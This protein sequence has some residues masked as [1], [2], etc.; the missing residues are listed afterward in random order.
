MPLQWEFR[1]YTSLPLASSIYGGPDATASSTSVTPRS[2]RS[3]TKDPLSLHIYK[4]QLNKDN[5]YPARKKEE[6]KCQ[7]N[8]YGAEMAQPG[9]AAWLFRPP[10]RDLP[11]EYAFFLTE[12]SK[13][14][15]T[16]KYTTC[17][18]LLD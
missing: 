6:K 9:A 10:R 7:T 1:H 18:F 3:T 4:H 8:P 17:L 11:L 15:I 16:K 12:N 13:F 2:H 14:L 5:I